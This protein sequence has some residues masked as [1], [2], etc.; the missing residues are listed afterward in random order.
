MRKSDLGSRSFIGL[1]SVSLLMCI[2]IVPRMKVQ[3]AGGSLRLISAVLLAGWLIDVAITIFEQKTVQ[4][5][6]IVI[7]IFV[8]AVVG[9]VFFNAY[10]F[11]A[12]AS[13]V[14]LPLCPLLCL[15]YYAYHFDT[16]TKPKIMA[17][18]YLGALLSVYISTLIVFGSQQYII[19]NIAHES[20]SEQSIYMS[21]NVGNMGHIYS[22]SL[23]VVT[24]FAKRKRIFRSR[25]FI[26]MVTTLVFIVSLFLVLEGSSGIALIT[27]AIGIIWSLLFQGERNRNILVL[28]LVLILM[29]I[30]FSILGDALNWLSQN[31]DDVYISKKL[32]DIASTIDGGK[33]IG[34]VAARFKE[35]QSDLSV[36]MK[37]YGLGIGSQ[38]RQAFPSAEINGHSDIFS[39]MARYGVLWLVMVFMGICCIHG[40]FERIHS[41]K[42][43]TDTPVFIVYLI[44]MVLQPVLTEIE[45]T[46]YMFGIFPYVNMLLNSKG[47]EYE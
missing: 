46:V 5:K 19:R 22:A 44:M 7:F 27:C 17:L 34:D 40:A 41:G 35:Y 42:D 8:L 32:S 28:I 47:E 1:M 18:V 24:C 38:Y 29:L 2:M 4:K 3:L 30:G 26:K 10:N 21:M 43:I 12:T 39:N 11:R 23:I 6:E 33:A 14:I 20:Y 37:S 45:T 36:F 31:I 9:L 25:W 13:A 15:S 16:Y